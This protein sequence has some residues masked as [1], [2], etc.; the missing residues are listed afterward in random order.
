[1]KIA[2]YGASGYTGRLVLAELARRD[3]PAVLAGRDPERLGAAAAAAGMPTA[4]TAQ[5]GLDDPA[6]LAGAFA[7]CAALINCAGPFITSG[8]PVV[9]AAIAAG[10]H[11]VDISGEQL[12]L[13]RVFERFGQQAADAGVTV[14]PGVNDDGLPSSLIAHL[15]AERV[16][17]VSELVIALDLTRS[18][19][20]PSRGTLRS[21]LANLATFRDGGLSYDDGR[22]RA[23]VPARRESVTF[24]GEPG[25]VPVVK[26]PLPGV[27]TIPRHVPASHVEGVA[28]AVLVEAFSQITPELIDAVP[29]GPSEAS[30]AAVR[31][32][33]VAEA[34]GADGRCARGV[35]SGPDTYGATAVIVVESARQLASQD[36]RP[37]VLAP[38]Q[39]FDPAGFLDF[40]TRYQAS[41]S[42]E[43]RPAV[44]GQV[45]SPAS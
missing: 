14:V 33:V 37:G 28:R 15:A 25:P 12:Y 2:V 43:S 11:Y 23:G 26:F 38:A 22:W 27:V 7:G 5:A 44:S 8:E 32:T 29:D 20:A 39:A 36:A 18:G 9:R 6:A 30:R 10:C 24:A 16:A 34:T 40:L 21:A 31:W 17:P 35:V 41:W 19:A 42:I 3:I 45:L 4:E 1:M 13:Q